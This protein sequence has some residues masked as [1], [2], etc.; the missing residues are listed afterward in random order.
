MIKIQY[1]DSSKNIEIIN[2]L[3]NGDLQ[4][5]LLNMY[6]LSVYDIHYLLYQY[7]DKQEICGLDNS[8]FSKIILKD[9]EFIE[10]LDK[11]SKNY[12]KTIVHNENF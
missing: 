12:N 3:T 11:K 4:N 10:I 2:N 7:K 8:F 9:I 5:K 1:L 6:N